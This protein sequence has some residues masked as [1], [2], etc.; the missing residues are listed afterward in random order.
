MAEPERVSQGRC[1]QA[2]RGT[3]GREGSQDAGTRCGSVVST[4][5]RVGGHSDQGG[6]EVGGFT[7]IT[8][9]ARSSEEAASI[10]VE[11]PDPGKGLDVGTVPR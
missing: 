11:G 3:A 1:G 7:L 10:E 9:R 2:S 8:F 6:W 4:A 5:L